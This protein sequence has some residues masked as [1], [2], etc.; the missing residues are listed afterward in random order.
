MSQEVHNLLQLLPGAVNTRHIVEGDPHHLL[1]LAHLLGA[2]LA[3]TSSVRAVYAPQHFV[4][5]AQ[6]QKWHQRYSNWH[7]SAGRRRRHGAKLNPRPH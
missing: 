5:Q 2:V 4:G 1:L 7:Q 3:Y 6:V